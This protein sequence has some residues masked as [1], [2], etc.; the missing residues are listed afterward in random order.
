MRALVSGHLEHSGFDV[1]RAEDGI[2]GQADFYTRLWKM[3]N[4]GV[5]VVLDV[6]RGNRVENL[7]IK[8]GD[9]NTYFRTK[10]TY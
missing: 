8:S 1:Q 3:G 4:A 7:S 10:A 6:L 5:E 2:K 9:R